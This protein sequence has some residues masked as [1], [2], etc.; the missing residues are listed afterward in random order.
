MGKIVGGVLDVV[1]TFAFLSLFVIGVLIDSTPMREA[2]MRGE[3]WTSL[4][5]LLISWSPTN[6]FFMAI[7][8]TYLGDGFRRL[9]DP[10]WDRLSMLRSALFIGMIT[11]GGHLILGATNNDFFM[12]PD[13]QSYSVL[14]G[15]IVS[16]AFT[17]GANGDL[18]P[19]LMGERK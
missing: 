7:C 16:G 11:T 15:L 5:L 8:A 4:P 10:V 13:L 1:I 6:L 9:N 12:R 18:V 2:F 19:R 14:L 17:V 3:G